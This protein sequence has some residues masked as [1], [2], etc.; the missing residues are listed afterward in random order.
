MTFPDPGNHSHTHL[1][2]I[3]VHT[4]TSSRLWLSVLGNCYTSTVPAP[5]HTEHITT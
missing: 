2:L 3:L 4:S 5:S 1:Q